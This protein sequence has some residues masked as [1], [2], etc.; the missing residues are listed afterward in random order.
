MSHSSLFKAFPNSTLNTHERVFTA[1]GGRVTT[2]QTLCPSE[3]CIPEHGRALVGRDSG[4]SNPPSPDQECRSGPTARTG[5]S[6]L[7]S[8]ETPVRLYPFPGPW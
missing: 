4:S 1:W 2:K 3:A 7:R 8:P 6:A 5:S